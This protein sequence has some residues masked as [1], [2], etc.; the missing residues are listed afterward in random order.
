ME[1]LEEIRLISEIYSHFNPVNLHPINQYNME[2][3][4][5]SKGGRKVDHNPFF[6]IVSAHQDP[7]WYIIYS[8]YGHKGIVLLIA[9][10][11]HMCRA[12]HF[13]LKLDAKFFATLL[14]DYG[15]AKDE[16]ENIL[17]YII[18]STELYDPYLYR[19][20]YLFSVD[21]LRGFEKAKYFRD[22]TYSAQSILNAINELR[23]GQPPLTM[24]DDME[25]RMKSPKQRSAQNDIDEINHP[26]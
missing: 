22:R 14:R 8:N 21:F 2:S 16:C 17:S 18:D 15:I 7:D 1:K 24:E 3:T 6:F 19:E 13:R 25:K 10:S 4:I 11:Q 9:I 5:K 23:P 26:E 12:N 20:G